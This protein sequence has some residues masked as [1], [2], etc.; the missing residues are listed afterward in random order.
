[1]YSTT[2]S[3]GLIGIVLLDNVLDYSSC[4]YQPRVC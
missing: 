3:S 1:M 2:L 4:I